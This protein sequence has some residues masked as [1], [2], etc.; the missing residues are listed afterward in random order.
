[1]TAAETVAEPDVD[2]VASAPTDPGPDSVARAHGVA[3]VLFLVVGVLVYLG[4]AAKLVEPDFLSGSAALSYGRL[5]PVSFAALLY[6]WLGLMAVAAA[7]YMLPRLTG[8]R[9]ALPRVA[10]LNLLV[11]AGGV[12]AGSVAVGVAGQGAGGRY[13]ELPLWSD[14]IVGVG[15]LVAAVVATRT[16]AA[17]SDRLPTAAWYLVGALWFYAIGY[18]IGAVP[19]F[20]GLGDALQGW[21]AVTLL[22]GL[23]PA[24]AGIGVAYY[25]LG[26]VAGEWH[27][28]L[29]VLAFWSLVFTWPWT[30][31][32]Y[33]QYGPAEEWLGTVPVVF[34]LGLLVAVVAVIADLA[35]AMRGRFEQARRSVPITFVAVGL[36]LFA[37][38]PLVL[39]VQSFRSSSSVVHLT[40]WGTGFEQLTLLGAF[41][42]LAMAAAYHVLGIGRYWRRNFAG[43]HLVLAAG[44]LGIAVLSRWV[45]GLQAGYTW[46]AG[47]NSQAYENV[48][49]GFRNTLRAA[50]GPDVVNLVGLAIFAVSLL[51]FLAGL[52]LNATGEAGEV[53]GPLE[54]EG[55]PTQ[56]LGVVVQGAF[57]LVVA[58][59]L[60]VFVVPAIDA[61]DEPSLLAEDSPSRVRTDPLFERG[62]E[63]YLSEGCWYCHTQQVRPIVTDVGLGPVS[64]PGDYVDSD[65]AVLGLERIGPDLAHA[66]SREP[67]NSQRLMRAYLADPRDP[68]GDAVDDVRRPWSTMPAYGHLSDDDLRALAAYV[69]GLE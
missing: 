42:F 28:R 14:A 66:G 26:R 49:E 20:D 40:A 34:A 62:Y 45:S 47:V 31:P 46:V 15:F 37:L 58:A 6:G 9:L 17:A 33:L 12:A 7:Y 65:G 43:V 59:A 8:S 32:H 68:P 56:R 2:D 64:V 24:S 22:A 29:G 18:A 23:A 1:M 35:Y 50:E 13:L 41:G 53:E 5:L 21:F 52:V 54:P 4:A 3:A 67:T 27:P 30:A 39:V 11:V 57:L 10:L 19:L 25:L 61:G 51:P 44:G 48:G 55:A 63:L 16:A 69:T 60:V 36:A 38:V